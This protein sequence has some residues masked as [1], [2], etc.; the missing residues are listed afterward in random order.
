MAIAPPGR[1]ENVQKSVKM[2][3][4]EALISLTSAQDLFLL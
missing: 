2:I 4:E 3:S 1:S